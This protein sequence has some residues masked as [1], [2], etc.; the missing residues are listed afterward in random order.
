MEIE[1]AFLVKS[2]VHGILPVTSP[3][4]AFWM[5]KML[6]RHFHGSNLYIKAFSSF[7]Y[8]EIIMI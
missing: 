6:V 7:P 3:G 1:N 4:V 2:F 5:E 8:L